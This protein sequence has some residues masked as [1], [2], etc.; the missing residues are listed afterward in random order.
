MI[1][2]ETEEAIARSVEDVWAYASDI[3]RHPDWMNVAEARLLSGGGT[4]VGSRG[5]ERLKLGPRSIDVDIEVS[6]SIPARRIAWRLGGR[7]PMVGEVAL[8]LE[9]LDPHRTRAI[10]S[11]SI[12]LTG[13]WRLI[14][15]LM[16]GEVMANVANEL[17]RLKERLESTP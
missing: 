14:E 7:G 10:W 11:G 6:D 15:P 3:G 13:L 4:E 16:A 1:K 17:R 9:S 5:V 8:D 2:F 12:G